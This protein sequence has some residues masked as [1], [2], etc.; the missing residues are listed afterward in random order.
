MPS[1]QRMLSPALSPDLD[2]AR[3]KSEERKAKLLSTMSAPDEFEMS[4]LPNSISNIAK[5]NENYN[6][7]INPS[8][9]PALPLMSGKEKKS[10][11]NERYC[12]ASPNSMKLPRISKNAPPTPTVIVPKKKEE[13]VRYIQLDESFNDVA[14]QEIVGIMHFVTPF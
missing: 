11:N 4:H 13:K 6:K 1:Q 9:I 2:V 7:G 10:K 5:T 3:K 12:T 8:T 14:G